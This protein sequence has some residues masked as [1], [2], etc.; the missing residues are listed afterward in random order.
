MERGNAGSHRLRARIFGYGLTAF[1]AQGC[2]CPPCRSTL[3]LSLPEL[4]DD[5]EDEMAVEFR[6]ETFGR[7]LFTCRPTFVSGAKPVWSCELPS[8]SFSQGSYHVIEVADADRDWYI[9]ILDAEG[10]REFS[11]PS[12]FAGP[13]EA[14]PFQCVCDGYWLGLSHQ[15]L[16]LK[17]PSPSVGSGGASASGAGGAQSGGQASSGGEGGS[18]GGA[19][20]AAG[21]PG[22][23]P[24]AFGGTR[25]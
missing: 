24:F 5:L 20:G 21:A 7:A 16:G 11:S 2:N 17:P 6:H 4:R 15:A 1:L 13:N 9:R 12:V 25:L 10:S 19:A 14:W 23:A 8:G 18:F 22:G 3:E